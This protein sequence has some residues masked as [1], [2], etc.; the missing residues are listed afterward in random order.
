MPAECETI[1]EVTESDCDGLE[2]LN[3][4]Q[5]VRFLEK[6]REEWYRA[7]GLWDGDGR[8]RYG[9]VVVNINYNYR[10][11]CFLGE[12]LRVIS[13]AHAMGRK[14]FTVVHQ[15]IKPDDT[16]AIEG[17]AT[18]VVMDLASRSIIAVPDCLAEHLPPRG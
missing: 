15:V 14:S 7:C 4:V 3:H 8:A 11:E 10:R 5:A 2:H 6:A 9:T 18:S 13:K 1:I 17:Q 16:L 12:R